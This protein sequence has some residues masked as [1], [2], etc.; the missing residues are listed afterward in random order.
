MSQPTIQT[1]LVLA[2]CFHRTVLEGGCF[3]R[4][5][6]GSIPGKKIANQFGD[7]PRKGPPKGHGPRM[8]SI[9]GSPISK[10]AGWVLESHKLYQI[11]MLITFYRLPILFIFVKHSH[12]SHGRSQQ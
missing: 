8:I 3:Q 7:G 2:G 11:V 4:I 5:N 6:K 1:V 9:P 12:D 10:R